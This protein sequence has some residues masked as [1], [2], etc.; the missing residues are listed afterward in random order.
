MFKRIIS[1]SYYS[2]KA[3]FS[4]YGVVPY[5]LYKIVNSFFQIC[6]FALFSIYLFG[7]KNV[8]DW[9]IGNAFM[10]SSCNSLFGVGVNAT[11]ER[12]FG[13][14]KYE[15]ASSADIVTRYLLQIIMHIFDGIFNIM[16]GIFYGALFFNLEIDFVMFIKLFAIATISMISIACFSLFIGNIGLIIR[17]MSSIL[18]FVN[19]FIMI[20][21]GVNYPIE[22]M[23]RALRVSGRFLPLSGGI[24]AARMVVNGN[25][26]GIL[27][28]IAHETAVGCIYIVI[29]VILYKVIESIAI[30]RA[31][32]DLM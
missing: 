21:A 25:E 2:Y 26:S 9:I 1:D 4:Y 20:C 22:I 8:T 15:V 32:I 16:L 10:L 30:R 14:L 29:A 28:M 5:L 17:D 31:K 11:Y 24:M 23:P 18:N 7:Q 12:I 27:N 13:T 19:M 3:M 6:F